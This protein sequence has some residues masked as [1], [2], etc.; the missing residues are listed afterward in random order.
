MKT[1]LAALTLALLTGHAAAGT[2][3]LKGE[4]ESGAYRICLYDYLGDTV[5]ITIR[6]TQLCPLSIR[7]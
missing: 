6:V 4:R 1:F 5:A 7:V 3:F 2:A